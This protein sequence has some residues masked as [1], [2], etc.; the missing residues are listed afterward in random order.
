[1]KRRT[2]Y[3][4]VNLIMHCLLQLILTR[5][6]WNDVMMMKSDENERSKNFYSTVKYNFTWLRK[7]L[8]ILSLLKM[9]SKMNLDVSIEMMNHHS[10]SM[11]HWQLKMTWS[12]VHHAIVLLF[13]T[14]F[15][16]ASMLDENMTCVNHHC[17][18]IMN[19]AIASNHLIIIIYHTSTIIE[20]CK[21]KYAY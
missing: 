9:K 4:S 11:M 6:R 19:T 18:Q 17:V 15:A 7:K 14:V 21:D 1:V 2:I 10:R 20:T 16:F 13:K 5:W 8:L 3:S 12:W